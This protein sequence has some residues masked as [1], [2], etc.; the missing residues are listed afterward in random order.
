MLLSSIS[1][2]NHLSIWTPI[3]KKIHT[4]FLT[5]ILYKEKIENDH[6]QDLLSKEKRE[7]G[8]ILKTQSAGLRGAPDLILREGSTCINCLTLLQRENIMNNC[9]AFTGSTK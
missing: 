6:S 7:S 8:K 9:L 3:W 1:T 2:V 4:F 5:Q